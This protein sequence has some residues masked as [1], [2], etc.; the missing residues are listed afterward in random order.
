[1]STVTMYLYTASH[2]DLLLNAIVSFVMWGGS[3]NFIVAAA[4]PVSLA[5]CLL[6]RLPCWNVTHV[7][8]KLCS[9]I[10]YHKSVSCLHACSSDGPDPHR[11]CY[12]HG[13]LLWCKWQSDVD[14][15]AIPAG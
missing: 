4:D 5:D 8:T 9:Q 13:E 11:L 12:K 6:M 15:N 14:I 3:A 2:K 1:M 10:G 7:R